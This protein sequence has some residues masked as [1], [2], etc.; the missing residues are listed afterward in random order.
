MSKPEP[1]VIVSE[2]EG[3]R[4]AAIR[5]KQKRM[6]DSQR[7]TIEGRRRPD[8]SRFKNRPSIKSPARKLHSKP[9]NDRFIFNQASAEKS[10]NFAD[11]LQLFSSPV[12]EKAN[13][14]HSRPMTA[15]ALGSKIGQLVPKTT[16]DS[17]ARQTTIF[18]PEV[19]HFSERADG[20]LVSN[21]S[22][23]EITPT[24]ASKC[25][26]SPLL[27]SKCNASV[28]PFDMTKLRAVL[29][30]EGSEDDETYRGEDGD[31]LPIILSQKFPQFDC[32]LA[33]VNLE[34]FEEL[35]Y[36]AQI[37]EEVCREFLS[38]GHESQAHDFSAAYEKE[39]ESNKNEMPHVG[40][41]REREEEI[42]NFVWRSK[43]VASDQ[44]KDIMKNDSDGSL[45][46]HE[47]VNQLANLTL[48]ECI[49]NIASDLETIVH[50]YAENIFRNL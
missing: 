33:N 18:K 27:V 47:I 38:S 13:N 11:G 6:Y 2:N 8:S 14:P 24:T 30:A 21:F 10:K 44:A 26:C 35:V 37:E 48:D 23:C 15:L 32:S 43:I 17:S 50:E 12:D 41:A 5:V 22:R 7:W 16:Q 25:N 3:R 31:I 39:S 20:E 28:S 49:A 40:I 19:R 42:C 36:T 46:Y 4:R 9:W 45:Q 29:N 1:E 34:T